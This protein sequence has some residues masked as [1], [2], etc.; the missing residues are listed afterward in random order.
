MKLIV[1]ED[2]PTAESSMFVP[3]WVEFLAVAEQIQFEKAGKRAGRGAGRSALGLNVGDP[4]FQVY[5]FVIVVLFPSRAGT[6]GSG[7]MDS[8]SEKDRAEV[9][10]D[11][12]ELDLGWEFANCYPQTRQDLSQT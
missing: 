1:E 9:V 4:H 7:E 8:M 11:M 6:V 12:F 10:T 3:G 5:W 2:Y